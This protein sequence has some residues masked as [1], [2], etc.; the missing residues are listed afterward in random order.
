MLLNCI[1][2]LACLVVHPYVVTSNVEPWVGSKLG[3]TEYRHE[4]AAIE[5]AKTDYAQAIKNEAISPRKELLCVSFLGISPNSSLN[6]QANILIMNTHCDWA[7]I[8]Y[9]GTEPEVASICKH[10]NISSNLVHCGR[11]EESHT[12][13]RLKKSIPKSV[14]YQS[15][16]PVLP[17]YK[18]VFLLDEDMSLQGF[19]VK[20]FLNIWNCAFNPQPLIVQ[21]LIAENNQYLV[22][23]N[24]KPWTEGI[25]KDVVASTVGYIEQQIPAFDAIF[26]EWFVRRVLS[27]TKDIALQ[28]AMDWG[29]DRSWCNAANM[30]AREV[31]H[32]PLTGFNHTV[33]SPCALIT[34]RNT[35]VHHLNHH[36]MKIIRGRINMVRKN[37]F[38]V[39]QKY[40]DYFP[41]WV[42][43][44]MLN[45]NNPFNPENAEKFRQ[46][47]ALNETC[48]AAHHRIE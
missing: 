41:T 11:S 4:T 25:Y 19:K 29:H 45:P 24:E 18:K 47:R 46:V 27:Q 15:L 48:V 12:A 28:Y 6:L 36:T 33:P 30:Y 5:L 3:T 26:F 31:L 42:G 21:P 34:S 8:M 20:E 35:A 16:L 10:A 22:F 14:Q 23:V 9:I 39:V 38:I 7:V 13:E 2:L 32:W 43:M 17:R 37:A 44:D 1:F 40:V